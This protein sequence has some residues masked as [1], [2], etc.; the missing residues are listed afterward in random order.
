[1]K[2][3]LVVILLLAIA[4]GAFMLFGDKALVDK[5]LDKKASPEFSAEVITEVTEQAD[6][7]IGV[8]DIN[9]ILMDSPQLAKVKND[10]KKKFDGREKKIA[11]A[12]QEFQKAIEAFNKNGPTMMA[13]K[14]KAEETKI[15]K[16]QQNLQ[17]MQGK[18]QQ[19]LGE[20]QNVAMQGIFENVKDVVKKIA[21]SKGLDL[22][23]AKNAVPY[24][25]PGLEMTDEIVMQLKTKK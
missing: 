1:M 18:F 5:F 7:K 13:D 17:Q 19:D 24:S 22:V 15:I 8:V 20:A 9:K 10:L 25:K 21:E 16:Q 11:D 14:K 23:I 12:Q 4:G 6:I 2:K 3:I